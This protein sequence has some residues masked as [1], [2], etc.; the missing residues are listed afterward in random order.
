MTETARPRRWLNI[1]LVGSLALNLF[2]AGILAAGWMRHHGSRDWRGG[3]PGMMALLH[4]VGGEA[5][6][7]AREAHRAVLRE[8]IDAVRAARGALAQRLAAEPFDAAAFEAALDDLRSRSGE[9][10]GAFHEAFAAIAATLSPEERRELA[11]RMMRHG[12]KGSD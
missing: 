11:E 3:P 5:A 10:Q 4:G 8:R 12:P 2:L 6:R 7:D 9:A 1:V